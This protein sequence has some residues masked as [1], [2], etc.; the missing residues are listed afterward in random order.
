MCGFYWLWL[1]TAFRRSVGPIDLWSGLAGVILNGVG[2]YVPWVEQAMGN[3]SWQIPLW[4]AAAIVV[5]RL[6]MAPYWIWRDQKQRLDDLEARLTPRLSLTFAPERPFFEE[7]PLNDGSYGTWVRVR[8]G[9]ESQNEITNVRVVLRDISNH[10]H[11]YPNEPL[12][13]I[14]G[15]DTFTLAPNAN[16]NVNVLWHH[17]DGFDM[18]ILYFN[19]NIPSILLAVRGEEHTLLLE[20]QG[21]NVPPRQLPLPVRVAV[22]GGLEVQI[23]GTW[24][25]PATW[26]RV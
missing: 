14:S 15:Q 24:R 13:S 2:H 21:H 23:D 7:G 19:N 26:V 10:I 1:K 9:N 6:L 25:A 8:V 17:R 5:V 11:A 4:A 3:L 22:Q 16:Q 18:R 12:S 20:A